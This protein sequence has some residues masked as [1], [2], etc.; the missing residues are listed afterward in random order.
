MLDAKGWAADGHL[1]A[2]LYALTLSAYAFSKCGSAP[3][4]GHL[5]DH[6]GRRNTLL[7]TFIGT[8]GPLAALC[9]LRPNCVPHFPCRT[10][11]RV[12]ARVAHSLYVAARVLPARHPLQ[13]LL[14]P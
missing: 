1:F 14:S 8:V 11:P 9:L 13:P 3:W 12:T 6:F 4:A 7:F 2:Y 10:S 5:S